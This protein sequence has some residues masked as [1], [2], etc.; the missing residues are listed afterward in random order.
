[1]L[2]GGPVTWLSKKQSTVSLSSTEYESHTL[3][4][5]A[6]E[7][8]HLRSLLPSLGFDAKTPLILH[9]DNQGTLNLANNPAY[10]PR[11]EHVGVRLAFLWKTVASGISCSLPPMHSPHL[12]QGST[13]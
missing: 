1:M 6:Q 11:T 5:A 2:N 12:H 3:S 10:S 4:F 13:C 7:A 9:E 8:H